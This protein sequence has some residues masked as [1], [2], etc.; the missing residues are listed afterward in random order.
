MHPAGTASVTSEIRP[1]AASQRRED[2]ERSVI[3]RRLSHVLGFPEALVY[4]RILPG[5]AV[6]LLVRNLSY[7]WQAMRPCG[8]P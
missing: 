5:D 3:G 4:G 7:P 2:E 6:S 1:A 8:G